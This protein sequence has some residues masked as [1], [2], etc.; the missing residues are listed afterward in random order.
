MNLEK[1]YIIKYNKKKLCR[2]CPGKFR[3]ETG[4]Y[5]KAPKEYCELC[6]LLIS[7]FKINLNYN[8]FSNNNLPNEK[9][10]KDMCSILV[11]NY[12]IINNTSDTIEDSFEEWV[13]MI[14]NTEN[15]NILICKKDTEIIGF[16]CYTFL[17]IGLMLSEVQIKKDYQ[18]KYDI[19]RKML[20]QVIDKSNKKLY[21][22][23]YGTISS[24]NIKSQNVFKHIGFKNTK[25]I[26]YKININ[27]LMSWINRSK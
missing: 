16:V 26:L 3:L 27:D 11:E 13:N 10:L 25:G 22:N 24:K 7:E 6:D 14:K 17:D 4:S 2:Y 19:L 12:N 9:A 23:V 8:L 15:Y 5:E 21:S 1:R 18:G 20:K